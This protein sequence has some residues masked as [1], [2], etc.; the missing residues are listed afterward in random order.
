LC[1]C[2]SARRWSLYKIESGK[3]PRPF[4]S[5][6]FGKRSVLPQLCVHKGFSRA[7]L[8][9]GGPVD[10]TTLLRVIHLIF[11]IHFS[12][13]C[14]PFHSPLLNYWGQA[15]VKMLVKTADP[16]TLGPPTENG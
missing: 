3:S 6:E 10:K 14:F 13:V 11:Y 5:S 1:L 4:T 8:N 9:R 12:T 2:P 16:G 15:G 7:K